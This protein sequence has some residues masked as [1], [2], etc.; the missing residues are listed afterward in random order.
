MR[1]SELEIQTWSEEADNIEIR[2]ILKQAVIMDSALGCINYEYFM[3]NRRSKNSQTYYGYTKVVRI[4]QKIREH[5]IADNLID[6]SVI[7]PFLI[8]CMT[9]YTPN[10]MIIGS[11]TWNALIVNTIT[12]LR[13]AI[14]VGEHKEWKDVSQKL[15]L[16][17][18]SA[19]SWS[20]KEV[21]AFLDK[22][23]SFMEN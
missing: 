6:G 15:P 9:W 10:G 5:M 2:D 23:L 18:D 7:T 4:M 22:A 19:Y 11:R 17:N 12:H 1:F 20:E 8:E 16:F 13:K 21:V 3:A 14:D